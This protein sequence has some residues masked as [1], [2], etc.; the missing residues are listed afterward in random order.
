MRR[1]KPAHAYRAFALLAVVA[2][3]YAAATMA[4][5]NDELYRWI[6]ERGQVVISDRPP[7]AGT[8]HETLSVKSGRSL[9]TPAARAPAE[10]SAA[11]NTPAAPGGDDLVAN[12]E[13]CRIARENLNALETAGRIQKIGDDGEPYFLTEEEKAI[14]KDRARSLIRVHCRP[15]TS[16]ETDG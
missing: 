1:S 15:G 6:D 4:Q 9:N 3:A 14:E 13:T 11:P 16:E 2:V 5:A 7:Q 12:P 10:A 8:P